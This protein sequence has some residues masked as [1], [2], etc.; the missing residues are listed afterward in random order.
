MN[1]SDL[2]WWDDG[3]QV[4]QVHAVSVPEPAPAS[5]TIS[6]PEL[7]YVLRDHGGGTFSVLQT[8]GG[9]AADRCY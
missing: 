8:L 7:S 9:A 5:G 1:Q 6:L 3:R 2:R 4:V